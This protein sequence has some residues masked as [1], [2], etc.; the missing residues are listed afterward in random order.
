VRTKR[1]LSRAVVVLGACAAAGTA[2]AQLRFPSMAERVAGARV[3]VAP[4]RAAF[5]PEPAALRVEFG[6]LELFGIPGLR[7]GG[8]R[9]AFWHRGACF[10]GSIAQVSSPVGAQSRALA[11]AGYARRSGWQGA[12]RAGVE[13]LALDGA[14]PERRWV[15]G[16]ISRVD[17]G[18]VAAIADV[19]RVAG[20]HVY[21]TSLALTVLVSAGAA[22]LVAN[23]RI[24]GDRFV[25][26]GVG[27]A[28][29]LHSALCLMAGYDDGAQTARA[30]VVVAWRRI[31][32]AAGVFQHPVLGQ[33]QGV[34]VAC[35]R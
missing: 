8:V 32:I 2:R 16:V 1:F 13:R 14:A 31:E 27:V 22:R 6:D 11:E 33:S 34:T 12:V 20:E 23:V 28:A 21:A 29:R 3:D 26:A 7:L 17:A 4:P 19:E 5:A 25:G 15:T 9:A 24:D 35:T 10:S 18:P 30:G